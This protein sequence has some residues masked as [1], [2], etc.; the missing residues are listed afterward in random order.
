MVPEDLAVLSEYGL[1]ATNR[2]LTM[3]LSVFYDVSRCSRVVPLRLFISSTDL[4]P[5]R[6]RIVLQ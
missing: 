5:T 2:F 1:H 6:P 3:T 4:S